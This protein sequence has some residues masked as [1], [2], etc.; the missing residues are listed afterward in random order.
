[1][2]AHPQVGQ[3]VKWTEGP[4]GKRT[5]LTGTVTHAAPGWM[6]CIQVDGCWT[7]RELVRRKIFPVRS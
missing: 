2:I 1:M 3:R 4:T 7:K 5:W 6:T